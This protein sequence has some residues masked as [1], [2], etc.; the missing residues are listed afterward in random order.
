MVFHTLRTLHTKGYSGSEKKHSTIILKTFF[1]K[2][3]NLD[4]SIMQRSHNMPL[5]KNPTQIKNQLQKNKILKDKVYIP[6]KEFHTTPKNQ[7][8]H[9]QKE[10][11]L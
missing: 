10:S 7:Y 5:K 1:Y 8:L 3:P 6:I 2:C 11:H 4:Q 9:P